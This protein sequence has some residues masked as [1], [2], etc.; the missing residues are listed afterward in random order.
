[1]K[2]SVDRFLD[3][4]RIRGYSE[5]TLEGRYSNLH[6]FIN[7]C[8]E[9]GINEPQ[10]VTR[11]II[12]RYRRYLYHYRQA[13]GKPLSL[14]TQRQR[15]TP[16]KLLFKWLT[17]ENYLLHN[18]ASE[19]DL[20][21][22]HKRLPRAILTQA[23]VEQVL[24][25]TLLFG[26]NGIRD[27]AIIETFYATGIRRAE[28]GNLSLDDVDFDQL[29]LMV[30]EGK[31]KKD[32][33]LPIGERACLW[34]D[35]Y[36]LDVRHTL[37]ME[38]DRG[39]LFINNRGEAFTPYQLS[40]LVKKYLLGAGITKQGACHLFRHT[41]ATLMLENGADIRFIQVM[42]GHADISTTQIYTHVAIGKLKEVYTRTHPA[43]ME[44]VSNDN[45]INDDIELLLTL[46]KEIEEETE[47]NPV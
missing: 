30:R 47:P 39:H 12:E 42:L 32:R 29:T 9:R 17:K 33:L 41:M 11:P 36:L 15:L 34:I 38:P 3:W 10:Q 19:L 24:N 35:K 23:E 46:E 4:Y 18:P 1:M 44:S 25:H 26:E 6:C 28:L 43:R 2:T 45:N 14:S 21:R 13:N 31:G 7:W 16:I 27:R 22:V 8:K 5:R 37:V 20:P 40:D